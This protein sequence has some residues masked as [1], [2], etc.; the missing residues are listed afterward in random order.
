MTRLF[1]LAIIFLGCSC[2]LR[3]HPNKFSDPIL[4]QIIDFQDRRQPDSLYQFLGSENP[5][6]R[7]ETAL[8]F[9]SVQDTLAAVAL[10]NILLEDADPEVRQAA[11]FA[12][13]QSGG[14][15]S[16][17]ALIPAT[18]DKN[19]QV[20]GEVLEA[21]GKTVSKKDAYALI[22]FKSNDS[23]SQTGLAWGFY[24]LGLR[25]LADSS[26]VNQCK[27]FLKLS[28][29]LKTRLGAAHFFNRSSALPIQNYVDQ[30]IL[31][32]T[33]D[34]SV[35]V[36]MAA[37]SGLRKVNSKESLEALKKVISTDQDY[38][39]RCNGVRALL[40]FSFEETQEILLAAL[41]DDNINIGIAASEVIRN[42]ATGNYHV[43]IIEKAR[44]IKNWRV[45]A[46]L[47]ET[48][49]ALASTKELIN[50]VKSVYSASKNDYQKSWL[51]GSLSKVVDAFPFIRDELFKTKILVIKSSAAQALVNINHHKNFSVTLKKDFSSIYAQAFAQGDPGVI[52]SLA[53][54]L[55]DSTL[56]Y[57]STITDFNFLYEAKKKLSL[58]K[59][60]EALQPLEQAI[61]YFE[62]KKKSPSPKN[63][64]NHPINWE[65]VK[66]I[67]NDQRVLLKTTKG[68]VTLQLMVEEAPGS[69]VN[70][71]ELCNQK[72]FD[73]KFFHR[74]VPNFVVQAGCNRGDGFGS[75][76][77]SIRSE[78][79]DRKY[80]EGSVGM[81]SAGKDTEGTQ[82]F[83]THSPTPHLD[84]K[85][86][87]F[88]KVERGMEVVHQIGVGDQILSATLV[89][90]LE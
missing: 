82:W 83:I 29:S 57:R 77:Y 37:A 58:P 39:V 72:Y 55:S 87:V 46:D 12:L 48:A 16:V 42:K 47:Y 78:F 85:Y 84:G 15:L 88:A 41:D 79:S 67:A 13:G 49:L 22:S 25:G 6:Y 43:E 17:N 40:A 66:T 2:S 74:V 45:Q 34:P 14:F 8:A 53:A 38:R 68:D 62:G 63:E 80:T 19:S 71:V 70:F 65:L 28:Y 75:E 61:A 27:E 90:G 44:T 4:I 56:D 18:S 81:A 10:G 52:V 23:L 86:T 1:I 26:V 50:E 31:T 11:A 5:I 54:A 33:T 89:K 60:I 7:K 73:G 76:S 21:L 32:A 69:V 3:K 20:V 59:D 36:R 51:L 9:A 35:Y 24:H 64:F 30:L